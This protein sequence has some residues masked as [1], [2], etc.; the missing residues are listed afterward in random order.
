[1]AR[2]LVSIFARLRNWLSGLLDPEPPMSSLPDLR[3]AIGNPAQDRPPVQQ[4]AAPVRP[5]SSAPPVASPPAVMTITS[6]RTRIHAAFDAG[7]PV[8]HRAGLAG[9]ARELD[10]LVEAVLEHGKHG[11]VFGARGSGKTSLSRVF[12]DLADEAGATVLYN[13]AGGDIDF[14]ELCRPYLVEL[15]S[16][17][18]EGVRRIDIDPMLKA[19]FDARQVATVLAEKVRRPTIFVLDEF[20]RIEAPTTKSEM[21]TLMKLLSD[22]RSPVRIVA[23]GIAA[24]LEDLIEGHPSLRRHIVSVPIGGI[25]TDQL[26]ALLIRCCDASGMTI[27]DD[28]A[29][30]I[31]RSAVGSP[32]HLR[33]FGSNCAIAAS[34]AGKEHID[35]A[36]VQHGLLDAYEEWSALSPRAAAVVADIQRLPKQ[37]A[38]AA[39]VICLAAAMRTR[40]EREEIVQVLNDDGHDDATIAA[41][42]A[43]LSPI[44]HASAIEGSYYFDDTLAPQFYLLVYN[45]RIDPARIKTPGHDDLRTVLERG[46]RD[47]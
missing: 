34:R 19:P 9:R 35:D 12:G 37:T 5:V 45:R 47:L 42:F 17:P 40:I 11:I 22:M 21:A 44:L 4:P 18:G 33:L 38:M 32:Y 41:A 3:I 39:A 10:R 43:A 1:M 2:P 36:M 30:K 14:S 25:E 27:E 24:N 31:A 6:Q 8:E 20:D 15:A 13:L 46:V 23:V 26:K 29:T 16:I 28:A 7:M